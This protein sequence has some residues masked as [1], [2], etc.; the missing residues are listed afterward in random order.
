MHWLAARNPVT[1]R[2][3]VTAAIRVADSIARELL[4]HIGLC[5]PSENEGRAPDVAS[6]QSVVM[7]TAHNRRRI[8]ALD[9]ATPFA[10]IARS[11]YLNRAKR[12]RKSVF[13]ERSLPH[14]HSG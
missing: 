5:A 2:T 14:Q 8:P 6:D 4:C 1:M 9:V 7:P 12:E 3:S 11:Q 10:P 13:A